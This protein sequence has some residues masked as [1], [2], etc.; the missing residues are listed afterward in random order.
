MAVFKWQKNKVESGDIIS[1]TYNGKK[2]NVIVMES[3][4]DP[5]R[6]GKFKTKDGKLKRFLHGIELIHDLEKSTIENIISQM[7]GTRILMEIDNQYY[8]Q[9]NFG[10]QIDDI[11]TSERAYDKIKTYVDSQNIY[12]T[13]DWNKINNVYLTNNVGDLRRLVN[14]RFKEVLKS[15]DEKQNFKD[16]ENVKKMVDKFRKRG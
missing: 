2:R 6:Y 14:P 7:G 10:K 15:L 8:Y 16:T 12:R 3:P 1:F 5:G 4:N 9:I 11:M 13:Y